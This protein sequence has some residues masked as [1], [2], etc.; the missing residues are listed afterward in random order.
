MLALKTKILTFW[1]NKTQ[2]NFLTMFLTKKTEKYFFLPNE[3]FCQ[4]WLP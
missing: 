2:T 4:F 1:P 3:E